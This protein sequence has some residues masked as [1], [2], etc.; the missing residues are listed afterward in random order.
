M[1]EQIVRD[2][3]ERKYVTLKVCNPSTRAIVN[4]AENH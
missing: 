3:F 1:T 2:E 4:S